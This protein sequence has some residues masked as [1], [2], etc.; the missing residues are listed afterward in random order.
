MPEEPIS[1]DPMWIAQQ[2]T[3]L[4]VTLHYLKEAMDR[5]TTREDAQDKYIAQLSK[6]IT[7]MRSDIRSLKEAKPPKI[8][9]LTA[10][11]AI[12]A[13]VAVVIS[14]LGQLQFQ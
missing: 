10:M 11:T 4:E 8:H 7:E 3:K 12:A 13:T 2:F 1:V 5:Q 9:A 14:V 6:D